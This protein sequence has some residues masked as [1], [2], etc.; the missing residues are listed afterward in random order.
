MSQYGWRAE[1]ALAC[2]LRKRTGELFRSDDIAAAC[3]PEFLVAITHGKDADRR[4]IAA[5][6][7][8]ALDG[9]AAR[10]ELRKIVGEAGAEGKHESEFG[11]PVGRICYYVR[12]ERQ[13][14]CAACGGTGRAAT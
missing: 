4:A 3:D 8:D 13:D 1:K 2:V 6:W 14:R 9:L 5:K 7:G 10:G 12:E 11:G